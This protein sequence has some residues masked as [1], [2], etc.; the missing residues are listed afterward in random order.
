M[1]VPL[2]CPPG[3]T[4]VPYQSLVELRAASMP[5]VSW[6]VSGIPQDDPEGLA[7]PRF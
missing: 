1:V 4:H 2:S 5:D 7:N 6:A 3:A